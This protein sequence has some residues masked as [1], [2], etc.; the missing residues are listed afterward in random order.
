MVITQI[1]KTKEESSAGVGIDLK[2]VDDPNSATKLISSGKTDESKDNEPSK[3]DESKDNET[4]VKVMEDSSK[5]QEVHKESGAEKAVVTAAKT[6]PSKK[7]SRFS[8]TKVKEERATES[9]KMESVTDSEPDKTKEEN[10]GIKDAQTPTQTEVPATKK[11]VRF[12]EAKLEQST[13]LEQSKT[14]SHHKHKSAKKGR[15]SVTTVKEKS[16]PNKADDKSAE[17]KGKEDVTQTKPDTSHTEGKGVGTDGVSNDDTKKLPSA[18]DAKDVASVAL[19]TDLANASLAHKESTVTTGSITTPASHASIFTTASSNFVNSSSVSTSSL[20]DVTTHF[21]VCPSLSQHVPPSP[22]AQYTLCHCHS[23]PVIKEN[24][25]DDGK[26]NQKSASTR[27]SQVNSSPY[28]HG[29]SNS[30]LSFSPLSHHHRSTYTPSSILSEYSTTSISPEHHDRSAS[31]S[32][33]HASP[34]HFQPI[35]KQNITPS[36]NTRPSAPIKPAAM[37]SPKTANAESLSSVTPNKS[38]SQASHL[39]KSFSHSHISDI[40]E[41]KRKLDNALHGI[42]H[43]DHCPCHLHSPDMH[44][45]H[46]SVHD[47]LFSDPHSHNNH[48]N[49]THLHNNPHAQTFHKTSQGREPLDNFGHQYKEMQSVSSRSSS[50]LQGGRD[51]NQYGGYGHVQAPGFSPQMYNMIQAY[52][53]QQAMYSAMRWPVQHSPGRNNVLQ[54]PPAMLPQVCCNDVHGL[55]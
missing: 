46:P 26:T 9:A 47:P 41:Y 23:L 39:S 49:K 8:V 37:K 50:S 12:D 10:K 21:S 25:C 43:L 44:Q 35:V 4:V 6:K 28:V 17:E 16:P 11:E 15:F 24:V 31:K 32:P 45:E 42:L 3:S 20:S 18:K 13:K 36:I 34:V 2:V 48:A 27:A 1:N 30:S 14:K 7:K 54:R 53:P 55:I 5:V 40:E 22:Q 33:F 38:N 51:S 52:S 29:S 19:T